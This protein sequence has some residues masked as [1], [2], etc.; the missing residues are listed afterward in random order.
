[1]WNHEIGHPFGL[2]CKEKNISSRDRIP[3]N[4]QGVFNEFELD[5][6]GQFTS[7]EALVKAYEGVRDKE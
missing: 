1:M 2:S 5:H 7:D 6:Q 4:Q 3:E